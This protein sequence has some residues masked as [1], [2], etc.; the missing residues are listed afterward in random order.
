MRSIPQA[1]QASTWPP[2]AAVRHCA[3]ARDT[4][5]CA[6]ET[7]CVARN[8]SPYARTMSATS[9][10]GGG[11][12]LPL[13]VAVV[14]DDSLGIGYTGCSGSNCKSSSGEPCTVTR[15]RATWT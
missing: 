1:S 14:G 15:V 11:G 12:W 8:V 7:W 13:P 5:A 2:R 6:W 4:R 10:G 9:K 3:I